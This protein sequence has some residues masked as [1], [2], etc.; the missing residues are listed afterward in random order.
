[1]TEIEKEKINTPEN[2]SKPAANAP[3]ERSATSFQ[4]IE[5]LV[6]FFSSERW[7]YF[8]LSVLFLSWQGRV[9]QAGLW[10]SSMA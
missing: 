3:A 9:Q 4:T 10:V 5:Y 8:W 6:Y 2:K 1:M 7:K